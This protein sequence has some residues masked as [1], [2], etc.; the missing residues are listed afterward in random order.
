MLYLIGH[1]SIPLKQVTISE[2]CICCESINSV[3]VTVYQK[4]VFFFWIPFLPA[5]KT[6]ISECA[7]CKQVL[8]EKAM[9]ENVHA[10]YQQLKATT[11]IPIWMYSGAVLF[12]LLFAYWQYQD[13]QQKQAS[14]KMVLAPKVGDILEVKTKDQQYTLSKIIDVK[15]DSIFLVSSNYQSSDASGLASLKDSSYTSDVSYISKNNLKDLF[16]KGDILKV[17]RK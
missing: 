1:K 8:A 2:K 9:T 7:Y 3:T 16:D 10:A 4:Y 11:C 14:A 12:I 13:M 6:G 17:D 5:G 15:N